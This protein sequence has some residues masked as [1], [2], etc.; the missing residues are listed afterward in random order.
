MTKIYLIRH[1][2]SE[3]NYLGK[4]Q[5][6]KNT[7]LTMLGKMQAE[8]MGN[9]LINENIDIIYSSDL[10]RAFNTAEIISEKIKKPI[11]KSKS[12]REINFGIWE[13][14][15]KKDLLENYRK[16]YNIWLKT[17]EKLKIEGAESLE[18]LK[19]RSI[20]WLDNII[21]EN[22]EKNIAI[23]SHSATLKVLLL[24]ILNIPLT[25]FKNISI[26]NVS[27]NIIEYRDYNKVL[28]KLND[29]SH[30]KGLIK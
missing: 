15:T 21:K 10:E 29:V 22:P 14:L 19:N 11:I 1:G 30:L 28:V 25:N 5:G 17:P 18:S 16:E 2:Q 20:K 8:S 23:I 7:K 26:S 13:G 12:I 3:W 4:V 27:L 24:G 9:R 6:Q